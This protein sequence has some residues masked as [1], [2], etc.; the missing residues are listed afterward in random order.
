MICL[1]L[2]VGLGASAKGRVER[3]KEI[4]FFNRAGSQPQ[5]AIG[6]SNYERH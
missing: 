2:V 4:F 1:L 5:G 6:I 3:N